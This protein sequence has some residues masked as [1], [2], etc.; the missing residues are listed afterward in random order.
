M[1]YNGRLSAIFRAKSRY[2]R[3]LIALYG[4]FGQPFG[5][6]KDDTLSRNESGFSSSLC[7]SLNTK[8][9]ACSTSI[10]FKANFSNGQYKSADCVI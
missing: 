7:V 2:G 9:I 1:H 6:M 4:H 3:P 10:N 5:S 8:N